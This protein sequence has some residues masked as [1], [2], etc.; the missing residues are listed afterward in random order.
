M[1]CLFVVWF[2]LSFVFVVELKTPTNINITTSGN[3]SQWH[4]LYLENLKHLHTLNFIHL[5][6]R[7]SRNALRHLCRHVQLPWRLVQN[8]DW[9][10]NVLIPILEGRKKWRRHFGLLVSRIIIILEFEETRAYLLC[11]HWDVESLL[12]M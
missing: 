10:Y 7:W 12:L 11:W 2:Y 9:K 4:G 5:D 3:K 6:V 8:I 1:F